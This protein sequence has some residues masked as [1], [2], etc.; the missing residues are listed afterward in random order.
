MYNPA[1]LDPKSD[2]FYD[3]VFKDESSKLASI[4]IIGGIKNISISDF[5]SY[6]YSNISV[7]YVDSSFTDP[8]IKNEIII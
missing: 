2:N 7:F 5:K 8:V 4:F 6:D 3:L 1:N